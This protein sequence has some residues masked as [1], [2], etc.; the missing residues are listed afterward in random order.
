[1]VYLKMGLAITHFKNSREDGYNLWAQWFLGSFGWTNGSD[2]WSM[3]FKA[4]INPIMSNACPPKQ[5][6]KSLR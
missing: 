4:T 2:D 3:V 5:S 1:M 6:H